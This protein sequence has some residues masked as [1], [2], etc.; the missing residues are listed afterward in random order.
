MG[1]WS[2]FV[3]ASIA[4]FVAVGVYVLRQLGVIARNTRPSRTNG[5]EYPDLRN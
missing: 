1:M 3:S 4:G 5:E 2:I